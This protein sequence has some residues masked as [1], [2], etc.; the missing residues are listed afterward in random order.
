[1]IT[2][3]PMFGILIRT[4]PSAGELLIYHKMQNGFQSVALDDITEYLC[5]CNTHTSVAPPSLAHL[6]LP[7]GTAIVQLLQ[8]LQQVVD[9]SIW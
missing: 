9:T 3:C 7:P 2:C 8:A 4:E 5:V 6:A 1:M